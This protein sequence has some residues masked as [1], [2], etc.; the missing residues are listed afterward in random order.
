M[1][2]LGRGAETGTGQ[3]IPQAACGIA[4]WVALLTAKWIERRAHDHGK[5]E[6]GACG[7]TK[8]RDQRAGHGRAHDHEH[9]CRA[10]AARSTPTWTCRTSSRTTSTSSRAPSCPS[11]GADPRPCLPSPPVCRVP[12]CPP[13]P[14]FQTE[15]ATRA[16]TRLAVANENRFAEPETRESSTFSSTVCL[17]ERI[18]LRAPSTSRR[19]LPGN[20][21]RCAPAA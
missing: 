19:R 6:R 20:V 21:S 17:S 8:R 10:A 2:S 14:P 4:L 11:T 7:A 13:T 5:A 18:E 12:A 9:D 16:R 15:Q 1:G 3:E